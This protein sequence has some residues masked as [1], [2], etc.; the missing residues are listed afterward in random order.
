MYLSGKET[1]SSP[2]QASEPSTEPGPSRRKRGT[3][4]SITKETGSSPSQA[5]E[6]ST[7]PGPSRRK[8]GTSL[9]ITYNDTD[10]QSY[11]WYF[12]LQM[13]DDDDEEES[14]VLSIQVHITQR[15]QWF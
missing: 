7:E 11:P 3:S 12:Q 15:V 1:G 13:Q 10:D 9:S 8:R 14:E 5:S 6:P 4:L 2:S